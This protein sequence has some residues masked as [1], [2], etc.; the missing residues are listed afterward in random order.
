[1]TCGGFHTLIL[2]QSGKV[3]AM[4]KDDF[5]ILG[6]GR[7]ANGRMTAGTEHPTLIEYFQ[8]NQE[9][10]VS[11]KAG[12]WHSCFVGESGR[13]FTCGKGEYGRLGQGSDISLDE[14][15]P[16]KTKIDTKVVKVCAGGS[17]TL[18]LTSEGIAKATGRTDDGRLGLENT[19]PI[20]AKSGVLVPREIDV[21]TT[22]KSL[23]REAV[24]VE[25]HCG[26]SHSFVIVDIPG[27]DEHIFENIDK[28]FDA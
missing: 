27:G 3:F 14:P 28:L 4:G 2:G 7:S 24:V 5:G 8:R 15:T 12:G 25:V 6:I 19:S 20:E 22:I 26:G 13:L 9:R 23:V 18:L 1:M 16:V 21:I 17:H 11:I 10:I